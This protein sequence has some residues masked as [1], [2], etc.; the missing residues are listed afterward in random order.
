MK[1]GV[2]VRLC[3]QKHGFKAYTAIF[4]SPM[5]LIATNSWFPH[6]P[7]TMQEHTVRVGIALSFGMS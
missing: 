4:G 1:S 5:N 6:F 3:K 2:F 7:E